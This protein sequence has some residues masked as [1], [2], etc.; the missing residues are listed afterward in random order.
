VAGFSTTP[1]PPQ[2]I[3]SPQQEVFPRHGSP[4]KLASMVRSAMP[5]QPKR[6]N[7]LVSSVEWV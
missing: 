5:A 3:S 4:S 1:L 7:F 2:S 6:S